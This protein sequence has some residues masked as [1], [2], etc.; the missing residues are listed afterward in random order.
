MS[1]GVCLTC[2]KSR[3]R[4]K[5]FPCIMCNTGLYCR[6]DKCDGV[7][8]VNCETWNPAHYDCVGCRKN[9]KPEEFKSTCQCDGE[10]D[11]DGGED[12]KYCRKCLKQCECGQGHWL[13]PSEVHHCAYRGDGPRE[14]YQVRLCSNSKL[15]CPCD[16]NEENRY[17]KIH[18]PQ[19][20]KRF[21]DFAMQYL[22]ADEE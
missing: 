20:K 10:D 17:C 7:Q 18:M 19:T 22:A 6:K 9:M 2:N 14:C 11:S 1:K 8:C 13:C 15:K 5:L 16:Q 3:S 21:R 12:L 4:S